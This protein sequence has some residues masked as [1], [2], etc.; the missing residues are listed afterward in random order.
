MSTRDEEATLPPV[1]WRPVLLAAGT[2]LALLLALSARYGPHRDELYFVAA[3]KRLD[4]GYPDQP[5]LTPLL[6]RLADVVAPGSLVAL[7]APAALMMATVV[8]LA[9]LLARELGGGR[10]AQTLT[11]VTVGT[12]V[13]VVGLGHWLSTATTDTFFWVA[14]TLLVAQ[15]LHR[16]EPRRWLAVGAVAGVG[17]LDKHL[18]AFLLGGLV[19]GVAAT[20]ATRHHLRSA[21]T[22]VGAV[23]AV[24]IWT[25]NLL[26]QATHG[27]PQLELA[28]DIQDEFGVLEERL[29]FVV[30]LAV[31]LSPVAT[32]L[33]VR[34][35][36]RLWRAPELAW[37]KPFAW[38]LAVL[39]L[40]FLV[41]GG[42]AYY[43]VGLLPVLVAAGVDDVVRTRPPDGVRRA[44]VVLAAS[45]AI[46][47]PIVLPVLPASVYAPSGLAAI[48]DT[49][50]EMIGW[51]TFV[52]TV[53]ATVRDSGAQLVVTGNYGEAGA[54]AWYGS[55]V[56]VYSGHNGYGEWGP[57]PDALDG[58]LVLVGF[59][60]V[61]PAWAEGCRVSSRIDNGLGLDN[62]EQGGAVL[63]CEGTAAPWSE[64][65]EQ[66]VHLSA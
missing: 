29:G 32:V 4:W 12:G 31:L 54:L 25:P 10:A 24:A 19:L 64:V 17:L 22:W 63:A 50:A 9:G 11:A 21:W 20:P 30:L 57:P 46:G 28:R 61:G 41:S 47:W 3:G 66:V 65:W 15:A 44:G 49:Q 36:R 48:D 56:P 55:P 14:I 6:A 35:W 33:W 27:W 62:E 39:A 34:G 37:A 13:V 42:K 52:E 16:D 8:V 59:G 38:A 53:V 26:W 2:L 60:D 51:P 5:P 18:V 40:G 7:H 23:L 43:L 45:A 58:P 1:A